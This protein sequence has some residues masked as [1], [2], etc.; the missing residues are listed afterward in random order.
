MPRFRGMNDWVDIRKDEEHV[1]RERKRAQSLKR[2]AW[3][4]QQVAKGL[5]HY[6][7]EEVGPA[8]LTM[9]HVVPVARGGRSTRGNVVPCCE[10]CNKNKRFFTPAELV[11]QELGL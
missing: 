7:G 6:C 4:R 5:C 2:S 9:D 11:M 8:H 1:L 3:W 10:A